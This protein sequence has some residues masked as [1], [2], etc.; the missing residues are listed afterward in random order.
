MLKD[1]IID[2]KT[3]CKIVANVFIGNDCL[4]RTWNI[5]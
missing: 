4:N 1:R 2:F 5:C 3:F